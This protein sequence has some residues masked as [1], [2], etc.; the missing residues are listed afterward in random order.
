MDTNDNTKKSE[1]KARKVTVVDVAERAGVS[2]SAVSRAFNPEA[3]ISSKL[4]GKVLAAASELN[5]KPNR[6]ARGIKSRSSL[7]GILVTDFDNPFYL[8][9]LSKFTE[10]IQKR[11]CHSL[12]IKVTD[13]LD[14]EEAVELVMEYN[15]DGLIITSASLPEAL[16]DACK[17]QNTPVVIFGRNSD[18][19]S[20]TVVS[21]DNLAA[22]E[23]AADIILDAGYERP[24]FVTGPVGTSATVERQRGFLSNLIKRGCD[25]WQI[26]EGGEFSYDAGYDATLRI[27]NSTE[28]PDSLF[29]ADDIMACGGMDA[30][31]YEFGLRVPEDIGI[32]GVDDIRLAKSR[33]Y[34]LSTI[35]Q[36]YEEMISATIDTL[37]D[38]I[39]DSN[40]APQSITLRC[41]PIIRGST[42][43][44]ESN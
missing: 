8:P 32:V 5:Y 33:A 43:K 40:L 18:E 27:F 17:A 6:L 23:L 25:K 39:A 34:D 1:L 10:E 3:S 29:F 24:A 37:F 21:C 16:S 15:V 19:N 11:N 20:V 26:V 42:K 4:R 31:R 30:V 41:E 12:L 9:V 2:L 35:R 22:G 28:K 44:S 13:E 36:P 38:H 7:I 14:I